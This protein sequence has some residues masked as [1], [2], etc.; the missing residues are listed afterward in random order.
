MGGR[1]DGAGEF[2]PHSATARDSATSRDAVAAAFAGGAYDGWK[3]AAPPAG[4]PQQQQQP[5]MGTNPA[6]AAALQMESA[7]QMA[8]SPSMANSRSPSPSAQQVSG[9]SLLH[10]SVLHPVI[11]VE[12]PQLTQE[13]HT[14]V[15]T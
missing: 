13:A 9:L 1:M 14:Y 15:H 12:N 4:P 10:F 5:R 6:L 3:A 7:A 8:G 2:S 11:L